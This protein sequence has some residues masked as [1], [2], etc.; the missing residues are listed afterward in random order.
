[1]KHPNFNQSNLSHDIA[2]LKLNGAVDLNQYF[3]IAC[4]PTNKPITY[5][6]LDQ[7]GYIASWSYDLDVGESIPKTYFLVLENNKCN[8]LSSQVSKNWTTQFCAGTNSTINCAKNLKGGALYSLETINGK[9]KHV[10]TGLI[11]GPVCNKSNKYSLFTRITAYL[12]W[13]NEYTKE[14]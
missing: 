6:N 11:S 9:Q 4:L 12:D 1:M 8:S 3:Q 10:L 14:L 2:L 7:P 5:P 13:I